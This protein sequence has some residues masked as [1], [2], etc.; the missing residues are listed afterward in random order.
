MYSPTSPAQ[1]PVNNPHTP[2]D[3]PP[4]SLGT[5]EPQQEPETVRSNTGEPLE[6]QNDE[7]TN[8]SQEHGSNVVHEHGETGTQN[9]GP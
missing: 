7:N 1:T 3:V 6:T 5:E 8:T 9:Y 2:S 4:Q